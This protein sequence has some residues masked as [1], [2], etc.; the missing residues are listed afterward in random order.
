M[1]RAT[2][3]SAVLALAA[4]LALATPAARACDVALVL[5][6]D[7]SDSVDP[8]EYRLQVDGLAGALRDTDILE[9]LV[10]GQMALTVLQWSGADRQDVTLPWQRMRSPADVLAFAAA[11]EAMPRAFDR[12][13]TAPG[14]AIHAGLA[15]FGAVPD[16]SR[17]VIDVSGDGAEN[18]GRS[19]LLA[20]RA[21]RAA[22]VEVNGLA[23]E[24]IGLAITQFY[25]QAVVTPGGFVITA[26]T[27]ADYARAIRDKILRE[28]S[29]VTG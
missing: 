28:I 20:S 19:T 16:C 9:T 13:D 4:P 11:A 5:A 8:G 2:A 26:R 18:A 3:L 1:R 10:E 14:D 12:S 6:I 17:R 27:H 7:V 21:A 29:R 25:R 15:L 23:I 24:S 22:G